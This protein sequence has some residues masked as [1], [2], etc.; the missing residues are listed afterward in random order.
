MED[1]AL[2]DRTVALVTHSFSTGPP[3]E[4]KRFLAGKVRRLLYISHP[5][6][7]CKDVRSWMELH[8]GSAKIKESHAPAIKGP[9]VMYYI[10]DIF[11][12]LYY[13]IKTGGRYDIYIGADNLNALAGLILRGLGRVDKVVFY[14]IDYIPKRF[15]NSLMNRVYHFIDRLCC[16]RCDFLWNISPNMADARFKN[17]VSRERC[18]PEAVV[19]NGSNF[20]KIKRLTLAEIDRH[21][22]AFM[23]HL[24]KNQGVELLLTAFPEI[25]KRVKGATLEII[26]T[27]PL[28]EELKALAGRLGISGKVKFSGFIKDHGELEERLAR[29]AIG[30]APYSPSDDSF[31]Y[32]ADPGKP[33]TYLAAGLPV[34]ITDVPLIAKEIERKRAGLLVGYD[35]KALADAAI[36]LLTDEPFYAECR[37]NAIALGSLFDW[38]NVFESAVKRTFELFDDKAGLHGRKKSFAVQ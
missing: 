5:F 10:K 23:G 3:Q 7:Y 16:N 20:S 9:E 22:L 18:A 36:R 37:A 11:L 34:I 15:E 25:L 21:R 12:T 32:Y 31:T 4:L 38:N 14:T 13:T 24:R 2:Y 8:E 30:V 35:E 27:G 26:G 28:E 6:S 29:S 33:K 1:A 19:P 17:R